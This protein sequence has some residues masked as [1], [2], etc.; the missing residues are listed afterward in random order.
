[1][2]AEWPRDAAPS[3]AEDLTELERVASSAALAEVFPPEQY[4]FPTEGVCARWRDTLAEPGV[5]TLV[6]R[7]DGRMVAFVTFDAATLRHLAVHPDRWGEGLARVAMDVAARRMTAPVHDLWVLEDNLHARAV[8]EKMGWRP[9]GESTP[10]EWPP[11]P[12]L[13]RYLKP[14]G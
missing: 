12:V 3:D 5:T 1:M 13:L 11:H 7:Q 2:S 14:A 10:L 8:Y 9:S 4:P 6:W